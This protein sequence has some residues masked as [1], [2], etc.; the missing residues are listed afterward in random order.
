M[1]K[2][3]PLFKIED[4]EEQMVDF[5]IKVV[6]EPFAPAVKRETARWTGAILN[7]DLVDDTGSYRLFVVTRVTDTSQ[8]RSALSRSVRKQQ[9]LGT[10]LKQA[11]CMTSAKP[12]C[13]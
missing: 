10:C 8:V 3:L 1:K 11:R 7:V 2:R 5:T 4:L 13:K 6:V 9:H 12:R